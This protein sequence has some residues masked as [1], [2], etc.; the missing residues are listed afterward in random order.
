MRTLNLQWK[1]F[2]PGVLGSL[3]VL[4]VCILELEQDMLQTFI[5]TSNAFIAMVYIG[6]PIQLLSLRSK[7]SFLFT[8][9][10]IFLLC[11]LLGVDVLLSLLVKCSRMQFFLNSV[12]N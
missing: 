12:N 2:V 8:L 1:L 10:F 11:L 7:P 6:L 4:F 9:G 5:Q 3:L